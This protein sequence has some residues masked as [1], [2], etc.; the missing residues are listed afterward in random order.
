MI[1]AEFKRQ[2]DAVWDRVWSSGIS[3]PL[4][5]IEYLTVLLLLRRLAESSG[6]RDVAGR[7]AE[8]LWGD[9]YAAA[10]S[11]D[12]A[13]VG[14]LAA[15]A[16]RAY[17]LDDHAEQLAAL[18][19]RDLHTLTRVMDDV[20]ALELSERNADVLGDLFEYLLAHLSTAGHFGQFRTPR[21]L[22]TTMVQIVDP[23]AGEVVMDP[24]CGTAGFLVGA[25]EHRRGS[26]E[27]Y[28]GYEVDAN[29]H[30]LARTNVLLHGMG[31][32]RIVHADSLS[33]LSEKA[34]VILANPPFAGTVVAE[35][36]AD[37]ETPTLKTE[38]LFLELMQR[39]L[40][41]GGRACVVVPTGV[42]TSTSAAARGLRER[43]LK[44]DTVR[45]VI[46]LPSGVF[47]PYTD[48]KTALIYWERA[49]TTEDVRFYR[50]T[51]D[52]Y[53]LDDR[54]LPVPGSQLDEVVRA[55]RTGDTTTVEC[56]SVGLDRVLRE[57]ANL[58]P[59]RY[60]EG[61][62]APGRPTMSFEDALQ[63]C[64]LTVRHIHHVLERLSRVG[65]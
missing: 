48:V 37:F 19:A 53:S 12:A 3:N 54:R 20:Q 11:E 33:K 60:I 35:R 31:G 10:A 4:T 42:L 62:V 2:V 43:L 59:S 9:V 39:S 32:A 44:R 29:M 51:N 1:T 41:D 5:A 55:V 63:D 16:Q 30:R 18:L 15:E 24:G 47:R 23:V 7:P 14:H 46:E 40:L 65:G 58:N 6:H 38:L 27:P 57:R 21:H 61:P 25:H 49:T 45:A 36:V 22:V 56:A 17:G 34:H 28:V 52:G 8:L 50:I 13:S 26:D 64:E